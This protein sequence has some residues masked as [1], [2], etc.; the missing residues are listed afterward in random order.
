MLSTDLKR[1]VGRNADHWHQLVSDRDVGHWHQIGSGWGCW[2]LISTEQQV[3]VLAAGI[4]W[5][6]G[7][8]A[9]LWH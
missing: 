5:V 9:G 7:R 2:P 8:G 1:V 4:D 3:G 6:E